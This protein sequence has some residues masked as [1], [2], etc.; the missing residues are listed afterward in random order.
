[1]GP[2]H[3]HFMANLPA[4]AVTLP[5]VADLDA[6]EATRDALIAATTAGD[7]VVSAAAVER[8][9][10]NVLLLLLSAAE[11]ARRN[12]FGFSLGAASPVLESAIE[13]LGLGPAF[14]AI[15]G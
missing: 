3:G 6:V 15:R 4:R 14:A 11:T 8:V 13:R 7:V 1:M 10:T 5:A 2:F 9:S 12:G